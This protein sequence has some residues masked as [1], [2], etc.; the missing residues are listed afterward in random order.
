MNRPCKLI[1]ALTCV[2]FATIFS[3]NES[4]AEAV[5]LTSGVL[6][7]DYTYDGSLSVT[8]LNFSLSYAGDS[9]TG[10][11]NT[12]YINTVTYGSGWLTFQG[13]TTNSFRGIASFGEATAHGSVTAFA[14]GDVFQSGLPIFSVGFSGYGFLITPNG[15]A[16]FPRTFNV[17]TP[18]PATMLLLGTGLAGAAG[19]ARRRRKGNS[20]R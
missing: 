8:G 3:A 9:N 10:G 14:A 4:R 18:E 5:Y 12:I 15:T 6:Q 19:A 17:A 11:T 7:R 1:C 16:I 2:L 20:N 13:V